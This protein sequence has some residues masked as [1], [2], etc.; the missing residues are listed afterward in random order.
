MPGRDFAAVV[1]V[2]CGGAGVG[3]EPPAGIPRFSVVLAKADEHI[4][5][6]GSQHMFLHQRP[7]GCSEGFHP[8]VAA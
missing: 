7:G 1:G 3:G 5:Q 4:H 2:G 6:S 8:S